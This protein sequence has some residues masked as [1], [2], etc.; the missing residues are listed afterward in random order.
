MFREMFR[1]P[2]LSSFRLSGLALVFAAGLALPVYAAAKVPAKAQTAAPEDTPPAKSK[3]GIG[4]DTGMPVPRFVSLK[5]ARI[6][7][8]RGP[9]SDNQISWVF[10]RKSLPVEIIAESGRWRKIRDH[11]G[12]TGWVWHAMLDGRRSAIIMG[13]PDAAGQVA[14]TA[15]PVPLFTEPSEKSKVV[16][17]AEVGVI[18]Q[19]PF[20]QDLWCELKVNGYEGWVLRSEIWGAYSGE[21]FE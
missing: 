11:D 16:A 15:S 6:N 2:S 21:N 8:R 4:S 7:V 1:H 17:F 13:K 12:A 9:G 18:A 10:K 19:L 3:D 20:C 14:A 5:S